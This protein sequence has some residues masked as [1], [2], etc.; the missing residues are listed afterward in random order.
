MLNTALTKRRVSAGKF[1]ATIRDV[2]DVQLS[3][4]DFGE[5]YHMASSEPYFY[6]E[7]YAPIKRKNAIPVN[8]KG[9][10][11]VAEEV[12]KKS[13]ATSQAKKW[14]CTSE[15]KLPASEERKRI[16]ALKLQFDESSIP[17][18]RRALD[19]VDTGC[20]HFHASTPFTHKHKGKREYNSDQCR[21]LKGYPLP[22]AQVGSEC[23]STLRL[24]RAVAPHYEDVRKLLYLV[25]RAIRLH[26]FIN[27]IDVALCNGKFEAL[28]KLLDITDYAEL[29]RASNQSADHYHPNDSSDAQLPVLQEPGLLDL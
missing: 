6:D 22:C 2:N 8:D 27:S 20:P 18:L 1:L 29:L 21:E 24:L 25:Y 26:V 14:K 9:K 15:C 16:V 17:A 3:E 10:C 5:Q 13:E 7:S 11:V 19:E 23:L 4:E 28:C 12:G